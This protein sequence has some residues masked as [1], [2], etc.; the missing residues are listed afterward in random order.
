MYKQK[1]HQN[2]TGKKRAVVPGKKTR[3]DAMKNKNFQ[4]RFSIDIKR[5]WEVD[6]PEIIAP[7]DTQTINNKT[8]CRMHIDLYGF[9]SAMYDDMEILYPDILHNKE[10]IE[11]QL[12]RI[13]HERK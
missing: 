10:Y 13:L 4:E 6:V 12:Y 8:V 9:I 3:K 7:T 5:F 11:R 1:L 2:K